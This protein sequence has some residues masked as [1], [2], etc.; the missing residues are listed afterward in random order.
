MNWGEF[1]VLCFPLYDAVE[2][3]CKESEFSPC[4]LL[5]LDLIESPGISALFL[6]LRSRF[7]PVPLRLRVKL[8]KAPDTEQKHWFLNVRSV[9]HKIQKF[10]TFKSSLVRTYRSVWSWAHMSLLRKFS[11]TNIG[12][13]QLHPNNKWQEVERCRNCLNSAL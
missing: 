5:P 7:C 8:T 13:A 2:T 11:S 12:K 3:V 9:R 1:V 10:L 6:H 4:C